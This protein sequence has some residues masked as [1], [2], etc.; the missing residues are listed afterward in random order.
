M[1][2][3]V[4]SRRPRA[5]AARRSAPFY[6]R[7]ARRSRPNWWRNAATIKLDGPARSGITA[8]PNIFVARYLGH[9]SEQ[10]KCY[11]ID[12]WRLLRPQ[13][14]GRDAVTPRIWTT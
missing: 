7:R 14:T 4:C 8:M 11:F 12:L 10:A 9:S 13:F 5:W 3:R 1:A 6:W 2:A